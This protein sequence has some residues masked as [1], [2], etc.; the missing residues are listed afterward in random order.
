[1]SGL[2]QDEMRVLRNVQAGIGQA[3]AD[4]GFREHG[5]RVRES[6]ADFQ[7]SRY[8]VLENRELWTQTLH[9]YYANKLLLIVSEVTEAH[10]ELRTGHPIDETYYAEGARASTS[11]DNTLSAS[12]F[13]AS[14]VTIILHKPEGFLSELADV[15]IRTLDLADEI[16][17]EH[18]NFDLAGMVDEKLRY[19]ATRPHKHGKKF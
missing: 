1:V 11:I 4:K 18:P 17:R 12:V 5:D 10:D 14:L 9:D 13:D 7:G 2:T 8:T 15:L 16:Q 19:N 3:N 6:A